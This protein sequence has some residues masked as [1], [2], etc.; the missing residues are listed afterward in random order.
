M[1]TA[2]SSAP[3]WRSDAAAP[4]VHRRTLVVGAA[5]SLFAR[6]ARA[7]P[8]HYVF[9]QKIGSIE[10]ISRHMGLLTSTGKFTRFDAEVVLDSSDASRAA[11]DVTIDTGSIVLAWPGAED[12]LRSPAYFDSA[13]FPTARFKGS[14]VGTGGFERFAI[15]GDLSLRGITRPFDMQGQLVARRFVPSLGAEVADFNAGG[16]LSRSEFGMV[17]DPVMTGDRV[18][19]GVKVAIQLADTARA[20]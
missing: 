3:A 20:G 7:A 9:N 13:H 14:T 12:L 2:T 11:V 16:I 18:R 15:K 4:V 1:A 19:I 17:A 8:V 5:A 10:F 6:A